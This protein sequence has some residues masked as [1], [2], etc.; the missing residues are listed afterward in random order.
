M[1]FMGLFDKLFGKTEEHT[2]TIPMQ[3][4]SKQDWDFYLTNVDNKLSSITVDLGL[5]NYAPIKGQKNVVWVSIKMNKPRQDG[6]SSNEEF[7]LLG[8]IENTIVAAINSKYISA[9]VGRLTSN[10]YR[11]LYFYLGDTTLY[12]KTISEIMVSYPKYE[13]DFGAKEDKKWS[14]YFDFLYPA[15]EQFQR[16]QNRRVI[17]NLVKNGDKLTKAREVDHWIFFKSE[18]DRENFLQKINADGFVI[19]DKDFDKSLGELPY[20]LH[21]KRV[22]KIDQVSVD[23]YV[24]H[25]WKSALECNGDYDGWET[26]VEID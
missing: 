23:D 6:L 14:G 3:K 5:Y 21:I 2:S 16:I 20:R 17:D 13:Y 12:D 19:V 10:G 25:L 11:N 7:E 15:P 9:F 22:D 24:I 26:S 18:Q 8:E 4:E 1:F